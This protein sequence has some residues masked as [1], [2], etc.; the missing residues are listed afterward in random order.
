MFGLMLFANFVLIYIPGLLVLGTWIYLVK[1]S[2]PG[3]WTLLLMG[4]APFVI[5]DLVKIWGAATVT[6]AITPKQ[7]FNGEVDVE[8]ARKWQLF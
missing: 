5:G 1:G 4:V 2:V 6:K 7:A 3:I 8:R